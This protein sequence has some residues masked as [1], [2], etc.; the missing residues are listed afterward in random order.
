M[1]HLTHTVHERSIW[2]VW[3]VLE[4]E[5]VTACV[6][7][8]T[9]PHPLPYFLTDGAAERRRRGSIPQCHA[10]RPRGLM[11]GW[12]Q[13]GVR[14]DGWNHEWTHGCC[15]GTGCHPDNCRRPHSSFH[16]FKFDWCH[17]ELNTQ[18]PLTF[19]KIKAFKEQDVVLIFFL[20]NGSS[21]LP[22][23][24]HCFISQNL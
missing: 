16:F 2:T 7:S 6:C 12:T 5:I 3:L 10:A 18:L 4:N 22:R 21:W 15:G 14:N 13:I 9:Y 17:K 20:D 23:N 24:V 19:L 1:T 11:G 8:C